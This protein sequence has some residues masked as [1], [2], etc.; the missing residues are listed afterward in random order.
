MVLL[1]RS[2][3]DT[4]PEAD[5]ETG[6]GEGEPRPFLAWTACTRTGKRLAFPV[7][8]TVTV[9]ARSDFP[10]AAPVAVADSGADA[11]VATL[12]LKV[13]YV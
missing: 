7:L 9:Y 8:V 2:P 1:H 12:M 4:C 11:S 10:P 6:H 5:E 3:A 13:V